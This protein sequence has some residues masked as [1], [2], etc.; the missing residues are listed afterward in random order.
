MSLVFV[1]SAI[2]PSHHG[3]ILRHLFSLVQPGGS[4][5]FRDYARGDLAQKRF[6]SKEKWREPNLLHKD[7]DFYRRGDGTM[8][9]FFSEEYVHELSAEILEAVTETKIELVE[10]V[11][12]N[13]KTATSLRR[14]FIQA[15]WKKRQ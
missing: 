3:S 14:L 11:G 1:L 13:R 2:P 4:L 8:T 6:E 10:R 5:L 9:F 12:E 15:V 7:Y